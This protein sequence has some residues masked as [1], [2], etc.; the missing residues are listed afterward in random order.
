MK[1]IVVDNS[2][3]IK[4]GV[5]YSVKSNKFQ[6]R[7][8]PEPLLKIRAKNPKLLDYSGDDLFN[9]FKNLIIKKTSLEMSYLTFVFFCSVE[10]GMIVI[11]GRSENKTVNAWFAHIGWLDSS[12]QD[13]EE[14]TEPALN[15]K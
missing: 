14:D 11:Y 2:N 13:A 10:T 12:P 15:N 4:T 6:L 5:Y 9:T 8:Y 3:E 1:S 7:K